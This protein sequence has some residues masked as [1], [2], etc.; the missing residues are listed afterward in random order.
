MNS[1]N[2]KDPDASKGAVEST[3][4]EDDADGN[5]AS[6]NEQLDHRFQ[7]SLNKSSDSGMPETGQ[8]GEFSM[9]EQGVN[10]LKKDT[11]ETVRPRGGDA[12]AEADSQDQD[13]GQT[14]R[15]LHGD[16]KDD[17]LAS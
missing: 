6:L 10:E 5:M 2:P 1:K 4:P 15:H 3:R 9:E 11:T 12:D 7:D 17:P 14:Q 8:T 13:P 16:E